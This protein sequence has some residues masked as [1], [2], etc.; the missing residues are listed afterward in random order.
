MPEPVTP[1]THAFQA[2]VSQVLRLVIHSLY[3]HKEIFLRE[4]VS[5]ASDALDKLR[6]RA[7]TAQELYEGDPALAIRIRADR[8]RGTLTIDDTGIG[9]SAEELVR[10]LGTVAHSGSRAFLEQLAQS[11]NKDARLIGQFGV[12]FYSAYLVADRVEVVSRPA[13]A[14]SVA[15]RW[16]SEGKD[17]FTIEPAERAGRGTAITLHLNEDQKEFLDG[18]RIRALVKRYSDYVSHP[19]QLEVTKG[20]GAEAKTEYETVN[21]ASAL[22][23]RAKSEITEAEYDEFFHH[24]SHGGEEKPLTRAHFKV[25]GAQE[26]AG[27]LYVPR[28]RPMELRFGMKHRGVRLYVK[29]VLIMEDCDELA[30]EWMRFVVGVIDSDDLPL[31][32]SRELLQESSAV[33]TIKKQVVKHVLDALETMATERP[34]D[35]AVF[36]KS[37]GVFL[38]EGAAR[39]FENRERLS[40]L[41]RYESTGTNGDGVTSLAEYVSRMK[42]GQPA[43]YY[44]IGESR[45][46]L[47][48]APHLE[49]LAKRGYEALFMC[50]PIDQWTTESL[51]TFEGKP[52]VSAMRADLKIEEKEEDKKAREVVESAL[53]GIL[54]RARAVLG[55]KVKEVRFSDRL[56]D[57]PCCLVIAGQG[58]HAYVQRLLREAGRDV[59]KSERILELNPRHPVLRNLETLVERGDPQVSDWLELLYDQALLAEGAPLEDPAAFS[60]RVT[61]LLSK[62]TAGEQGRRN[63][64]SHPEESRSHPEKVGCEP[65]K[66]GCEPEKIGCDP[67]KIGSRT[68]GIEASLPDPR[69]LVPALRHVLGVPAAIDVHAVVGH[70]QHAVRE[71]GEEAT[72][73]GDEEH[74]PLEAPERLDE[75]LLRG[76]VEVVGRLVQHEEVRRIVEHL[77]QDHARLLP[78]GE[79]AAPLV[80]LV[81]GEPEGAGRA[82]SSG[83]D[84][85][86]RERPLERLEHGLVGVEEL[87][88]VLREVPHLH[89]RPHAHAAA[90]GLRLPGDELQE[91]RFPGA[92]HPHHAPPFAPANEEVEPVVDLP[93]AV[94][95]L[96]RFELGH[97]LARAGGRAEVEHA[98]DVPLRRLDPLDLLELLHPRLHLG[99]VRGARLEAG[100]EALSSLASMAC[101]R[102]YCA[103]CWWASPMRPLRCS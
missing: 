82:P 50:D 52:L 43:I 70:L 81:P 51:R 59:P 56:T 61:T 66:I 71:R 54:D 88:R 32:V 14:G 94:G 41:L 5:N 102:A 44:A 4:L 91:R 11:G 80:G 12:G 2:E 96:H 60:R 77:G 1:V 19:I 97:V 40:K 72:V 92:V 68:A 10:D 79:D 8:D 39:D 17:T 69:R 37:F 45:R 58:P 29:R 15:H 46:V 74:R 103:S 28:E 93:L 31:N 47:E 38:K 30:P 84:R 95:L 78:S 83:A 86:E 6:F 89:A 33:R 7:I 48:G 65:E 57:S 9:M 53:K 100:D 18:W 63:S 62:V 85:R 35:Y 13:G 64:G 90:V 73:V 76:H 20:A 23:Q 42:E 22:W 3:S 67:E 87:H 25:E 16:I 34:D 75:H 98:R 36:W 55:D 24:L 26:F 99:G 27:L 21:R 49:G 101:C